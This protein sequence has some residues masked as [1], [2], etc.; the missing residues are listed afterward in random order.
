MRIRDRARGAAADERGQSLV[1]VA[2]ALPILLLIVIGI[3]DIGRVYAHAIATESAAREAALYAARTPA[4]TAEQICQRARDELGAGPAALPC[5]TSP[6]TIVCQRGGAP[7]AS[8]TG[9][10][11]QTPGGG[12]V[13]VTVTYRLALLTGVLVGRGFGSSPVAISGSAAF[14]GLGE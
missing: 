1:E 9:V 8:D 7:C 11:W 10:L 3:V 5:S 4:A 6:M 14:T 12:D 13:R 2:L